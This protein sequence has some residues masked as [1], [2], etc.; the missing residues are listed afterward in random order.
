M[1]DTF[2]PRCRTALAVATALA[3]SLAAVTAAPSTARAAEA[4]LTPGAG[5]VTAS[6]S[7]DNA[8]AN[9]VDDDFGTRW[10][11]EGDG[12]WLQLDLG[13]AKTVSQVKLATYRGDSRRNR[14]QL[15]YWTGSSWS[16]AFDGSSSGTGTGLESFA[17]RPVETTKLRYVGHGYAGEDG[18]TGTWNSLTE[19]QVWGGTS[20]GDGDA[21]VPA[22]VLDLTNWKQTLPIGEDERPT[23]I[24]Q[25]ELA[26]YSHDPY[27]KVAS[28]GKSV[29]FRAPVNGVTTSGSKN[30]RSELRE[31]KN[32][33]KDKASWSTT[34]GT[35]T[36]TVRE[37]FTHLPNDRPYVVGAQI[38]GGSDDLTVFR[39]EGRKLYVTKEDTTHHKLVDDDYRLGTVFEAKFVA[40]G[41]KVKVYYNGELK[42]TISHSGSGN[43]FKAGAYTQANC[44]DSKPCS[45]S[46]YGETNIHHLTVRHD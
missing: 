11:G 41:G 9:V 24:T 14:F 31:M 46:N 27:F 15:Q 5:A 6:T 23:E 13:A 28:D 36:M 35:H 21:R 18:T 45:S 3:A 42:T 38:H 22:D 34:S 39:L 1:A 12:A 19:V 17:I 2:T 16:T 33:G 10:S 7:D 4:E 8:P 40:G 25:P 44:G 43:Y 20:D 30:P 26:R 37:A 29:Q 32:G